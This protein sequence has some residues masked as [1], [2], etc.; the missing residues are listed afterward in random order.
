MCRGFVGRDQ[1]TRAV[2]PGLLIPSLGE[3]RREASLRSDCRVWD[4]CGVARLRAWPLWA[5]ACIVAAA[6][7]LA[8]LTSLGLF[9]AVAVVPV[10]LACLAAVGA[11]LFVETAG[12]HQAEKG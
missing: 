2:S 7:A 3:Q 12:H 4:G 10:L 6:T 8:T 5:R 9:G 11:F 1:P